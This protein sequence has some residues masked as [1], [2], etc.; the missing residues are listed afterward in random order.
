M[1]KSVKRNKSV[2]G[3]KSV[4]R[5]KSV[6]RSKSVKRN[7][8]LKRSK[9]VQSK[10]KFYLR[11]FDGVKRKERDEEEKLSRGTDSAITRRCFYR[12]IDIFT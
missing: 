1:K 12:Y 2:K 4:K 3:K 6:K 5:N 8:S 7:K 10:K 9:S 11:L